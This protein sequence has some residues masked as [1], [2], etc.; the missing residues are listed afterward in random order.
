MLPPKRGRRSATIH[1]QQVPSPES[2][3]LHTPMS[4]GLKSLAGR[5]I[6]G[7][8]VICRSAASSSAPRP[9]PPPPQPP[10]L[11]IIDFNQLTR[12]G[13]DQ[14]TGRAR[15][16]ARGRAR[17]EGRPRPRRRRARAVS[18]GTALGLGDE[19]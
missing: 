15:G 16:Q 7:G 19:H 8:G 13:L 2:Q 12:G 18:S 11:S 14:A 3:P 17:G 10:R 5:K 9:S 1:Y 4:V 6:G